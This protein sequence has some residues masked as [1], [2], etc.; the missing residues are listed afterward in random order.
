MKKLT[1]VALLLFVP[2]ISGTAFAG[3]PKEI[4]PCYD[5][6]DCKTQASKKEFSKCIKTHPEEA[7]ANAGCQTFRQD[8]K[9]YLEKAGLPD[10]KALFN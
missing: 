9:A 8:K 2:A 7:N 3:G 4:H 1:V 10:I 5:V 6:A